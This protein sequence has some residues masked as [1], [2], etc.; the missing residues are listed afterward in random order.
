V[1]KGSDTPES[2]LSKVAFE[3]NLRKKLSRTEHVLV[4]KVSFE[5]RKTVKVFMTHVQVFFR[6]SL[7]KENFLVCH[8]LYSYKNQKTEKISWIS[9]EAIDISHEF[10]VAAKVKYGHDV[11]YYLQFLHHTPLQHYKCHCLPL[12]PLHRRTLSHAFQHNII[13]NYTWL[14][15]KC[16]TLLT[17]NTCTSNNQLRQCRTYLTLPS[18]WVGIGH[19]ALKP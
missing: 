12:Q 14:V 11:H 8:Y 19:P 9:Q 17:R 15:T 2:F 18:G 4:V 5:R 6:K 3:S 10:C 16:V 7:S 1:S 13:Q